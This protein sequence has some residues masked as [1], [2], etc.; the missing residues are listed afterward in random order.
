[1]LELIENGSTPGEAVLTLESSLETRQSL[2]SEQV[3][4]PAYG[5]YGGSSVSACGGSRVNEQVYDHGLLSH[6][7]VIRG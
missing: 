3:P 4:V 6:T 5:E 7:G 1:M 2:S